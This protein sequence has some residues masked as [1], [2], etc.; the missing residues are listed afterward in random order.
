M[1][2]WIFRGYYKCSSVR[3]C[4][5]R[6]HVERALD[7]PTMLI[8]TYEREHNH[9]LSNMEKPALVLESSWSDGLGFALWKRRKFQSITTVHFNQS[10]S[11][12]LTAVRRWWRANELAARPRALASLCHDDPN[13]NLNPNP[14]QIPGCA[15]LSRE[16]HR[17]ERSSLVHRRVAVG[18][19]RSPEHR[20]HRCCNT[21]RRRRDSSSRG[22]EEA[23]T[24]PAR[25]AGDRWTTTWPFRRA[26]HRRIFVVDDHANIGLEITMNDYLI[27]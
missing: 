26:N 16:L 17:L 9:G 18:E 13:S 10:S 20:H 27:P 15:T 4:P 22:R 1:L 3:R 7:D 6:K 23:A 14:S 12:Q 2:W 25:A 21:W 19:G 5:A 11:S 24:T 8:V